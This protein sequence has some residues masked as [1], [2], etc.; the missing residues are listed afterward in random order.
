MAV[1]DTIESM[2]INVANAYDKIEEKGGVLPEQK[3]LENLASAIDTISEGGGTNIP[4]FGGGPYGAIAYL[5][6]NSQVTY[7]AATSAD[8]LDLTSG[9]LVNTLT[10]GGATIQKSHVLAYSFGSELYKTGPLPEAFLSAFSNLKALYGM[11]DREW[12]SIGS[13]FLDRCSSFAQSIT[14]PPTVTSIGVQFMYGADSFIGPLDVGN[15][16][17]PS[18]FLSLQ[19]STSSAPMVTI[20]VTLMGAQAP[21]WKD[22]LPDDSYRKL[23][24]DSTS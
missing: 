12:T 11:D 19:A 3:N 16:P 1:S 13:A 10:V 6:D 7:Y 21:A 8:D 24:V 4:Y 18:Q 5:N 14:L 15:T 2:K 23:V 17:P 20:G 22:A 9:W